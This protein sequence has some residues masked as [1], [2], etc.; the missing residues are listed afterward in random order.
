MLKFPSIAKQAFDA[1]QFGPPSAVDPRHII[2]V[3]HREH[4]YHSFR[5]PQ[6]YAV[7]HLSQGGTLEVF[8]S[9]KL[10]EVEMAKAAE[11]EIQARRDAVRRHR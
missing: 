10:V 5:P 3:E 9:A 6:I 8:T 4:R 11:Q 1:W 2:A 7:I